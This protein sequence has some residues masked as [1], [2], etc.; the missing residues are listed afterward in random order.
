MY[1]EWKSSVTS[2]RAV[3]NI[4]LYQHS[5]SLSPSRL[6]LYLGTSTA[7][8][9]LPNC[10]VV[11]MRN[12]FCRHVTC[13]DRSRLSQF[14]GPLAVWGPV[15][16]GHIGGLDWTEHFLGLG[17]SG[18]VE[19]SEVRITGAGEEVYERSAAAMVKAMQHVQLQLTRIPASLHIPSEA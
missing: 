17:L 2:K 14:S 18:L 12:I 8:F 11:V 1:R 6:S 16:S 7:G 3:T 19:S 10:V 5:P 15:Q 9:P 4:R 13:I